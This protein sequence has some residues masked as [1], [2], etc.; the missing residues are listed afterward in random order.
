MNLVPVNIALNHEDIRTNL[1][2]IRELKD[3]YL[4]WCIEGSSPA[5]DADDMLNILREFD[6]IDKHF[7]LLDKKIYNVKSREKGEEI[8]Y[9]EVE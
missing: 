6:A 4:M 7:L 3:L 1:N 5:D 9:P 8:S 2:H